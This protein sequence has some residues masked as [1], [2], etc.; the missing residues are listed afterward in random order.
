MYSHFIQSEV[1]II[2]LSLIWGLGL[3]VLFKKICVNRSNGT[4]SVTEFKVPDVSQIVGVKW[5]F[6]NKCYEFEPYPVECT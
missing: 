4:C 6:G 5:K 1:G 2:L 3:A